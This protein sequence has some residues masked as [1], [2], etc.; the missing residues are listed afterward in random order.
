MFYIYQYWIVTI[1]DMVYVSGF[2]GF[3]FFRKDRSFRALEAL[4]SE[5][6]PV[7]VHKPSLQVLAANYCTLGLMMGRLKSAPASGENM[8]FSVCN[9]SAG[10]LFK[11]VEKVFLLS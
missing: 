1:H 9:L 4:L 8:F 10:N 5:A 11:F 7:L 6:L 3:F 2:F